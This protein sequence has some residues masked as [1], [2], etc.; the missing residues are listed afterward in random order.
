MIS[1]A[2]AR[3]LALSYN[4]AI[5]QPHFEKTSFRVKKKIFAT[6]DLITHQ[7]VLQF[8]EI[9][10]SVFNDYDASIIYPV[11][12]GWGKKGWTMVELKKEPKNLFIDALT[13]SY[14]MVAPK[15]IGR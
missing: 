8:S 12:G 7:M 1:I 15:K 10:Q 4:E 9:D 14:C 2:T 13:T 11:P 3:N 5:E 6:L